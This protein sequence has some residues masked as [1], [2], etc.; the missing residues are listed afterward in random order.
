M[1]LSHFCGIIRGLSKPYKLFSSLK[2]P[3]SSKRRGSL[4]CRLY[5]NSETREKFRRLICIED[6]PAWIPIISYSKLASTMATFSVPKNMAK[7]GIL[8]QSMWVVN[9]W[10]HIIALRDRRA[11][12][13]TTSVFYLPVVVRDYSIWI[14]SC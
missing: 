9:S 12:K 2:T 8:S 13:I 11:P 3:I 14:T 10:I 4:L 5:L 6:P 7:K 1:L